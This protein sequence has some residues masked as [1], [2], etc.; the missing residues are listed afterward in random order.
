MSRR[1]WKI[2]AAKAKA[3]LKALLD[4]IVNEVEARAQAGSQK[5]VCGEPREVERLPSRQIYYLVVQCL[6]PVVPGAN[7]RA[8]A[9]HGGDKARE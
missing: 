8:F 2:V 9:W 7:S 5:S 4:F 3:E 6:W 1:P